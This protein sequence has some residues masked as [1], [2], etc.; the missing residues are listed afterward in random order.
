M[1]I[2]TVCGRDLSGIS[3]KHADKLHDLSVM[4]RCEPFLE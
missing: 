4:H 3:C 1:G 2:V